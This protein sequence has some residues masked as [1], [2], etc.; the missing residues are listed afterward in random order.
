[1]L[2]SYKSEVN[3]NEI[4]R[5]SLHVEIKANGE[6]EIRCV[7]APLP[8]IIRLSLLVIEVA[9]KRHLDAAEQEGGAELREAMASD[10]HEMIN[11]GAST[12]LNRMFPE[13]EMR[14]DVTVEAILKAENEII[15]NN[16]ELVK[17]AHEAYLNSTDF[18]KDYAISKANR[19]AIKAEASEKRII[20][21]PD[22]KKP[23][24]KKK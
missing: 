4:A 10:M 22:H 6:A 8:E 3:M 20:Q 2:I 14:P 15:D 16:P 7:K 18:A 17:E 9:C 23:A 19:A 1:M 21:F 24:R 5:P 11:L 13:I 12:L